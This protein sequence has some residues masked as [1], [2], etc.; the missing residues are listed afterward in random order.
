[1]AEKPRCDICRG[2]GSIMLPIYR[3]ATAFLSADD[4]VLAP[5]S[6]RYPCPECSERVPQERL[7]VIQSHSVAEGRQEP[8]LLEAA[9][10]SAAGA[11]VDHLL[12]GG[13]IGMEVGPTDERTMRF[14]TRATIGV[15]ASDYV[16]SLERRISARQEDVAR[17]VAAEAE[18]QILWWSSAHSSPRGN[19]AKEQAVDA[20]KGAMKRVFEKRRQRNSARESENA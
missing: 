17:D 16:V 7:A 5:S 8:R 15:V 11:L 18:R 6:R 20:V 13:F 14:E 4:H 3:D 12:E 10:K 9:K 2:L 1:M 19:I